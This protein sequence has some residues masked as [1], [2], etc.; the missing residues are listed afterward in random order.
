MIVKMQRNVVETH[1]TGP[2]LLTP[3]LL[4]RPLWMG[5]C[6]FLL[7]INMH[8]FTCTSLIW[9]FVSR[10]LIQGVRFG[11]QVEVKARCCLAATKVSVNFSVPD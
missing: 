7:K 8:I 11:Q 5:G 1:K 3:S 2:L 6:K 4:N 10:N 9:L